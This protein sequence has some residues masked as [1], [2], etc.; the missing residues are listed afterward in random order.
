MKG[1]EL[2]SSPPMVGGLLLHGP[3]RPFAEVM[4]V[5]SSKR[6]QKSPTRHGN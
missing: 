6:V 4:T 3:E 2:R 5:I 1:N